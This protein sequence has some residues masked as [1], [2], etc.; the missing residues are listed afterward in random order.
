MRPSSRQRARSAR[1]FRISAVEYRIAGAFAEACAMANRS[2]G[3]SCFASPMAHDPW[4]QFPVSSRFDPVCH[5]E[6]S[7]SHSSGPPSRK[8][9]EKA[10]PQLTRADVGRSVSGCHIRCRQL[11]LDDRHRPGA[12]HHRESPAGRWRLKTGGSLARYQCHGF[13][14]DYVVSSGIAGGLRGARNGARWQARSVTRNAP[15]INLSIR[16]SRRHSLRPP[17]VIPIARIRVSRLI[18]ADSEPFATC[19]RLRSAY[20][21]VRSITKM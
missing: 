16:Q 7:A 3:V 12:D 18:S 19:G 2:G 10:T 4:V 15:A 5:G 21:R 20:Q 1:R 17:R 9:Q 11:S 14:T 6:A 8:A 13:C